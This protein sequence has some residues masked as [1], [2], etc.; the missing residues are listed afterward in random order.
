MTV[1]QALL[2]V[3]RK[4]PLDVPPELVKIDPGVLHALL[5]GQLVA[6]LREELGV[7]NADGP[8]ADR[9]H[10]DQRIVGDVRVSLI[11]VGVGVTGDEVLLAPDLDLLVV[12]HPHRTPADGAVLRAGVL[13]TV[14]AVWAPPCTPEPAQVVDP[15]LPLQVDRHTL[16]PDVLQLEVGLFRLEVDRRTGDAVVSAPRTPVLLG[17]LRDVEDRVVPV[18]DPV[19]VH[20]QPLDITDDAGLDLGGLGELTKRAVFV[21]LWPRT[22]ALYLSSHPSPCPCRRRQLRAVVDGSDA[23]GAQIRLPICRRSRCAKGRTPSTPAEQ[24]TPLCRP[25]PNRHPWPTRLRCRRRPLE[26]RKKVGDHG[27]SHH[28]ATPASVPRASGWASSYSA[29]ISR[30][31]SR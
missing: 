28:C 30:S 10:L 16:T 2:Q 7:L 29:F 4:G 9:L 5:I 27:T 12:D 15:A 8:D 1:H 20:E 3:A 17:H 14:L 19:R 6:V 21:W 11:N 13:P 24:G 31:S 22:S 18:I 23:A 25:G 26:R